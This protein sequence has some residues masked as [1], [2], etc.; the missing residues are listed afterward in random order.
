[1]PLWTTRTRRP[2]APICALDRA[3]MYSLSKRNR[4]VRRV[5][6]GRADRLQPAAGV[7]S[8]PVMPAA[9]PAPAAQEPDRP[10]PTVEPFTASEPFTAADAGI[11]E[12]RYDFDALI[13]R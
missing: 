4:S 8:A 11:E 13:A 2:A 10:E 12:S 1:M 9:E 6:A 3:A 7:R 5:E